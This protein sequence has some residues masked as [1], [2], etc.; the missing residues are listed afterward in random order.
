MFDGRSAPFTSFLD[1][2]SCAFGASILIFLVSA[3]T[4]DSQQPETAADVLLI[5]CRPSQ[6]SGE[7]VEVNFSIQEPSGRVVRSAGELPLGYSKFIAATSERSVS[8]VVIPKPAVGCWTVQAY[9]ANESIASNGTSAMLLEVLCPRCRQGALVQ[10]EVDFS[11]TNR[12]SEE[13][14]ID[15]EMA[16]VAQR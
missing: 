3:T 2:V 9:W 5:L 11:L 7:P 1:L 6:E 13:I 16:A 14:S 4:R 10:R 8:F 15:I 12:F